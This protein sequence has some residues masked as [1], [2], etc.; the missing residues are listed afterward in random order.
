MSQARGSTCTHAVAGSSITSCPGTRCA[1]SSAWGES[2]E[3]DR[4]ARFTRFTWWRPRQQRT[5]FSPI[6][7]RPARSGP[8]GS[9]SC[10]PHPRSRHVGMGGRASIVLHCRGNQRVHLA[11]SGTKRAGPWPTGTEPCGPCR[12]RAASA[13]T[14]GS[15]SR[16][17]PR[18][19]RV[20]EGH[21][22]MERPES[23]VCPATQEQ[24]AHGSRT[25]LSRRHRRRCVDTGTR[26]PSRVLRRDR[27]SAYLAIASGSA[28][29]R[30][31]RRQ[32]SR[33]SGRA[34]PRVDR[35]TRWIQPGSRSCSVPRQRHHARAR[36]A[37]QPTATGPNAGSACAVRSMQHPPGVFG[38]STDGEACSGQ[39]SA[40][41][42]P[43]EG[44]RRYVSS[45]RVAAGRPDRLTAGGADRCS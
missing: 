13:A 39:P 10:R 33:A 27:D 36:T 2:I 41:G 1:S 44:E 43:R 8:S 28:S 37:A 38:A 7:V 29:P 21:R 5:R 4:P 25:G 12:T 22:R 35:T 3:W 6:F 15:A 23:V 20:R 19:P 18:S 16:A 9:W 45:S 32:G 24:L 17:T 31:G 26:A 42:S 14:T 34:H 11:Q 30:T 40:P